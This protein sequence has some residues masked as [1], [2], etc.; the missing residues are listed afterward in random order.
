MS[1]SMTDGW[2]SA[3]AMHKRHSQCKAVLYDA[4]ADAVRRCT[5]PVGRHDTEIPVAEVCASANRPASSCKLQQSSLMHHDVEYEVLRQVCSCMQQQSSHILVLKCAEHSC[6]AMRHSCRCD[7]LPKYSVYK[8]RI[9][10]DRCSKHLCPH[11]LHNSSTFWT[12]FICKLPSLLH[13]RCSWPL[14]M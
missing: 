7:Q 8:P 12:V 3:E 13:A 4:L 14:S 10:P 5:A 9:L 6:V 2:S 11:V 1:S